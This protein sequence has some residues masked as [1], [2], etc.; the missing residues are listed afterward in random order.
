VRLRAFES[1]AGEA[2]Q[3]RETAV[4]LWLEQADARP[5]PSHFGEVV[6]D[7]KKLMAWKELKRAVFKSIVHVLHY[8][9]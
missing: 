6:Q 9:C 7:F 8:I 3:A 2:A 5:G 4:E 1:G